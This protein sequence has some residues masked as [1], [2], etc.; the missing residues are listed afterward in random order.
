MHIRVPFNTEIVQ[1]IPIP[2]WDGPMYVHHRPE[3][4][5]ARLYNNVF[6]LGLLS[7]SNSA[8]DLCL[9]TLLKLLT[10]DLNL[11]SSRNHTSQYVRY[12]C[13]VSKVTKWICSLKKRKLL[14]QPNKGTYWKESPHPIMG[15]RS[16]HW[17]ASPWVWFCRDSRAPP[18]LAVS[19]KFWVSEKGVNVFSFLAWMK[20]ILCLCNEPEVQNEVTHDHSFL[21]L[22]WTL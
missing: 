9:E 16:F 3:V 17:C 8:S 6:Y 19:V 21:K 7:F 18:L 4:Y 11:S 22:L 5:Y 15:S 10:W 2:K 12:S 14:T 13:W 1:Y 20:P